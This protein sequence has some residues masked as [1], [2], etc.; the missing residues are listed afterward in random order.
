MRHCSVNLTKEGKIPREFMLD[1]AGVK[2]TIKSSRR[3]DTYSYSISA[4]CESKALL[5]LE[6][7]CKD[8]IMLIYYWILRRIDDMKYRLEQHFERLRNH[9]WR[10]NA[11]LL[12]SQ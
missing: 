11:T 3:Y 5:A 2:R 12:F 10:R 9:F 8:L 1:R 7:V 4:M 6:A